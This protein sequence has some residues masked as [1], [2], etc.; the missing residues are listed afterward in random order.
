MTVPYI[1]VLWHKYTALHFYLGIYF[2]MFKNSRCIVWRP[3]AGLLY[4]GK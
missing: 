3:H 1:V 2:L 4:R